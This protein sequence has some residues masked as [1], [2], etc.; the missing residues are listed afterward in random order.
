MNARAQKEVDVRDVVAGYSAEVDILRGISLNVIS[1]EIV[2]ILGPNGCGKSNLVEA[3]R[4]ARE[5]HA[6]LTTAQPDDTPAGVGNAPVGDA[7]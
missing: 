4:I 7:P 3:L 5:E 2:C 1:R 6:D